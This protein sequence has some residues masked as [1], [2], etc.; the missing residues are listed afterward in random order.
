MKTYRVFLG[1]GSN[2]GDR[3]AYLVRAAKEIQGLAGV[4]AVWVSG[5]Y[6]SDPWGIPEQPKFLNAAMEV[7]TALQ[8]AD[9]LKQLKGIEGGVGRIATEHWGPRE[10][11][12]DI[13]LYDGVVTDE[14]EVRVP[15]QELANRRF[16]L[17]PLREI[18]PDLVHPVNGQT[19][20]ELARACGDQG[21][22][23]KTSYHIIL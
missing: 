16:A 7:E 1:L 2:L 15:H 17:V 9:L 6:E 19:M 21:K 8:P 22:V 14:P 20:E 23:V 3:H 10:I 12:I 4:R 13:L 18:A 11:D 5:V